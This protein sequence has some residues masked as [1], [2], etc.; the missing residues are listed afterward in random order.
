M[1]GLII[2]NKWIEKILSGEKRMEIRGSKT[3]KISVPVYILESGT[4]RIRG[5]MVIYKCVLISDAET[6][7][8]FRKW[9]QVSISYEELLKIYKHP[10]G[11]CLENVESC[12]EGLYYEHPKGAVIWVK[13]VK[14]KESKDCKDK[15]WG[16]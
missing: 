8:K 12:P 13:D 10:Y 5:K 4:S 7:D 11:W 6:W 3:G 16:E 15:Q 14:I 2:K 9:H 1:D